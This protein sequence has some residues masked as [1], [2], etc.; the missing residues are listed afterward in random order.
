ML[1][2]IVD[3]DHRLDL[4]ICMAYKETELIIDKETD[5]TPA[6]PHHPE[7]LK[8]IRANWDENPI[9]HYLVLRTSIKKYP[10]LFISK[11]GK[12]E[13]TPDSHT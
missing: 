7:R 5:P 1:T 4:F 12:A 6:L 2:K 10:A 3:Y 9:L 13:K 11:Y 8:S